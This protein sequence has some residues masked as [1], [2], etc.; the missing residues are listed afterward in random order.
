MKLNINFKFLKDFRPRK[1]QRHPFMYGL[2]SGCSFIPALISDWNIP[3]IL[4]SLVI[5]MA[6]KYAHSKCERI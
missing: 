4:L 2:L 6:A 1:V 3:G 5:A